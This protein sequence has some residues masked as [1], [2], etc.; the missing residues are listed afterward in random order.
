MESDIKR[1][2]CEKEIERKKEKNGERERYRKTEREVE[3][4]MTHRDSGEKKTARV[5][6]RMRE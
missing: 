6:I 3:R 4:V 5:K 2:R 1:Q